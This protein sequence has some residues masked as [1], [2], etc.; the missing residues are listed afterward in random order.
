[1]CSPRKIYD[2]RGVLVEERIDNSSFDLWLNQ[3][4]KTNNFYNE[5]NKKYNQ[6]FKANKQKGNDEFII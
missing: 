5:V 1:M 3:A 4:C 2:S 6:Y